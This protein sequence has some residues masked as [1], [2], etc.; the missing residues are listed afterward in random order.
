MYVGQPNTKLEFYLN[1]QLEFTDESVDMARPNRGEYWAQETFGGWYG[2]NNPR[3]QGHMGG[4]ISDFRIYQTDLS[5]SK[6]SQ[7]YTNTV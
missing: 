5:S 3:W 4:A 6:V 2:G 7:I 1:G